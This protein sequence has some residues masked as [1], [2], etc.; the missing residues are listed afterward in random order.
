M[1]AGIR[2]ENLFTTHK[3][4]TDRIRRIQQQQQQHENITIQRKCWIEE[5]TERAKKELIKEHILFER[6]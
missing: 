3:S 1:P 5:L 4:N 6:D 2:N